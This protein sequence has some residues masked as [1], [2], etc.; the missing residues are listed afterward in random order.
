MSAVPTSAWL[1]AGSNVLGRA[2]SP[3]NSGPSSANSVFGTN[4]AFDN[5]GW[6]VAL[7]GS[8]VDSTATK[9]D[10]QSTGGVADPSQVYIRYAFLFLGAVLAWKVLKKN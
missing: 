2:L 6:N 4:L 5:S 3:G 1:M 9:A 7:G 10:P 8:K